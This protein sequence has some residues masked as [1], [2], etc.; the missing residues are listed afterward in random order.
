[1]LN[2]IRT[3]L[4]LKC[5]HTCWLDARRGLYMCFV[6]MSLNLF[7]RVVVSM[8]GLAVLVGAVRDALHVGEEIRLISS[9]G[10]R[11]LVRGHGCQGNFLCVAAEI[12]SDPMSL[13][14]KAFQWAL[15]RIDGGQGLMH[16]D[17]VRIRSLWDEASYL[18]V[19]GDGCQGDA[20]CISTSLTRCTDVT[21]CVWVIERVDGSGALHDDDQIRIRSLF[22]EGSYLVLRG[23][24][25][26]FCTH[27]VVASRAASPELVPNTWR[28]EVAS[29]AD[30]AIPRQRTDAEAVSAGSV[31]PPLAGAAQR[32]VKFGDVA[33]A[34]HHTDEQ[35]SDAGDVAVFTEP[36]WARLLGLGPA[37]TQ[38]LQRELNGGASMGAL[39]ASILGERAKLLGGTDAT[40][41]ALLI[42][43]GAATANCSFAEV[44]A[45]AAPLGTLLVD[46]AEQGS[47]SG[48][49]G[50]RAEWHLAARCAD[51]R[52]DYC[53]AAEDLQRY[54]SRIPPGGIFAIQGGARAF[55]M[56]RCANGSVVAGGAV[57]AI[58]DFAR[59]RKGIAGLEPGS[60][61][62]R[63]P[64]A[65]HLV[66][67]A[68]RAVDD[69]ERAPWWLL[70]KAHDDKSRGAVIPRLGPTAPRVDGRCHEAAVALSGLG[71]WNISSGP[72]ACV[73]RCLLT[74]HFLDNEEYWSWLKNQC[75][76]R[77]PVD[78]RVFR[79]Q[80]VKQ[81]EKLKHKPPSR[82][83]P[84]IIHQ[85]YGFKC[86]D[87]ETGLWKESCVDEPTLN[88]A[89]Q[90]EA[91][92]LC[93][94][95][96]VPWGEAGHDTEAE[97][98]LGLLR[99]AL[100][101]CCGSE[102][103][104]R[105]RKTSRETVSLWREA[106]IDFE[107]DCAKIPLECCGEVADAV[108]EGRRGPGVLRQDYWRWSSSWRRLHLA[109]RY[110]LWGPM[111]VKQLIKEHYSWLFP[112]VDG[113]GSWIK[114]NDVAVWVI[115]HHFGGVYAN[116]DVE[117][118]RPLDP[119]L[120][121]AALPARWSEA[122]WLHAQAK[123]PH[124]VRW[125]HYDTS[126]R[127]LLNEDAVETFSGGAAE[128]FRRLDV[129]LLGSVPMHPLFSSVLENLEPRKDLH[130]LQAT[131]NAL[132]TD[133]YYEGFSNMV[134][135]KVLPKEVFTPFRWSNR[136]A[137]RL[138]FSHNCSEH[139]PDAYG[140]HHHSNS[141]FPDRIDAFDNASS[142]LRSAAWS[143]SECWSGPFTPRVCCDPRF[144]PRG[145]ADCWTGQFNYDRCCAAQASRS[146]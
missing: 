108:E 64:S 20:Y 115:L 46:D 87:W 73:R 75:F 124:E 94:G 103:G 134:G 114:R 9:A 110:V 34:A 106:K 131:G 122:A 5:L 12:T 6:T 54:W 58:E 26:Q 23:T 52:Q 117:A 56:L 92:Q 82:K 11:L 86:T 47:E 1:M 63:Q 136:T 41:S 4:T 69:S 53:A 61:W 118:L 142:T 96:A 127:V 121:G 105:Q 32:D 141:W 66:Q 60:P 113:Y 39:L 70:V 100:A 50:A 13:K 116:M 30:E 133:L 59:G 15:E 2:R 76:G 17:H 95:D 14:F 42:G 99:V 145:N 128:G 107:L 144:G 38:R 146:S 102:G 77:T 93:L 18:E 31:I 138:C 79:E 89:V 7:G 88:S 68:A 48:E 98:S 104:A 33:T 125:T 67:L 43:C 71:S 72:G 3:S 21:S 27:C 97:F 83:I 126:T 120:E 19:R 137:R 143:N 65:A 10:S 62:A 49:M 36:P 8:C 78:E 37:A 84:R 81:A 112:T 25:C 85:V 44:F 80:T 55:G 101:A 139:F 29:R 51:A 90:R 140:I 135:I 111:E 45:G 123:P 91:M 132:L 28:I 57:A 22:R 119:L 130:V 24:G 35:A 74:Q 16:G 129:H 40:T 109:W